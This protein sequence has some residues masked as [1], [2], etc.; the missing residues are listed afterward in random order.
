MANRPSPTTHPGRCVFYEPQIVSTPPKKRAAPRDPFLHCPAVKRLHHRQRHD[1]HDLY[2]RAGHLEVREIFV[3]H[4]GC[5][6]VRF[7]L[8]DGVAAHLVC[9]LLLE[10]KKT[11]A[12]TPG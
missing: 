1:L 5:R 11:I 7:S 8:D 6:F 2:P 4:H 9:R 10:K 3:E 12:T